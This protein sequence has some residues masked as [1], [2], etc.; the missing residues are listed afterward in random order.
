M[1]QAAACDSVIYSINYILFCQVLIGRRYF[2]QLWTRKQALL[3][4]HVKKSAID[5]IL[6]SLRAAKHLF[7]PLHHYSG[8]MSNIR[9]F[10]ENCRKEEVAL[11]TTPGIKDN[12][13]TI[14]SP[15]LSTHA[16]L[17]ETNFP[18]YI[19]TIAVIFIYIFDCHAKAV[20]FSLMI[21]I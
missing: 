15:I 5:V 14:L 3:N 4:N 6:T 16:N 9:Q 13:D 21:Y 8:L 10:P 18:V 20:S 11:R 2:D 1:S 7:S 17:H 12:A 19:I